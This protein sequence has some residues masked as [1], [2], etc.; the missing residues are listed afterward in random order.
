MLDL[1]QIGLRASLEI[2]DRTSKLF[3]YGCPYYLIADSYKECLKEGI[4]LKPEELETMVTTLREL[5]LSYNETT[6][7]MSEAEKDVKSLRSLW[8]KPGTGGQKSSRLIKLGVSLIAFPIPTIGIKKSLGAMLIAAG[9]IQERMKHLHVADV[10]S[11]FQEVSREI[12]KLQ[13][14][15]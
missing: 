10:Y 13:K 11:T 12:Q 14:S 15:V 1:Q 5:G 6:K 9:L 3:S 4:G 7:L 2:E 8:G